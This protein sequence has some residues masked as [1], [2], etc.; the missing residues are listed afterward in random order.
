[1]TSTPRLPNIKWTFLHVVFSLSPM[2]NF[3]QEQPGG[4][5]HTLSP[6]KGWSYRLGS[7]LPARTQPCHF[8]SCPGCCLCSF[9]LGILRPWD[10]C[11]PI[12][13]VLAIPASWQWLMRQN[14]QNSP[15]LSRLCWESGSDPHLLTEP[16]SSQVALESLGLVSTSAGIE[17]LCVISDSH[18]WK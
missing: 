10:V 5:R 13:A 3:K 6:G 11:I 4:G 2:M 17:L 15:S 1:M 12:P 18:I 16:G 7:V 8:L 9:P 14:C